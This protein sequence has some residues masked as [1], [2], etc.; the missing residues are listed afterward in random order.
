M[1]QK[2][3]KVQILRMRLTICLEGVQHATCLCHT[4]LALKGVVKIQCFLEFKATVAEWRKMRA[5]R[6]GEYF[7]LVSQ[8]FLLIVILSQ[9]YTFT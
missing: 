7:G 4:K 9:S 6:E 3:V 2:I 1:K 5:E 8:V